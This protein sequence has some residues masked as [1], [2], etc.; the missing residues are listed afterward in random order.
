ML[1]SDDFAP[2]LGVSRETV[3]VW[4]KSGTVLG[5]PSAKRGFRFPLWQIIDGQRL[6]VLCSIAEYLQTDEWGIWRFL[7]EPLDILDGESPLDMIRHGEIDRVL[8][9]AK[10]VSDEAFL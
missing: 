1:S 5:L 8:S 4:R 3:N 9:V 2:R 7:V 10:G 6:P